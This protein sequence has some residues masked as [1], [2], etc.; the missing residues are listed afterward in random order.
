MFVSDNPIVFLYK[1]LWRFSKGFRKDIVI[2]TLLFVGANISLLIQPF[3][4]GYMLNVIQLEGV[5]PASL[6]KIFW[7]L[8]AFFLLDIGNWFF[9]G[10]AR[11]MERRSAYRAEIQYKSYMLKGV[12]HLPAQWH[13]DHHSGDTIDKI[14]KSSQALYEFAETN[15]EIIQIIVRMIGAYAALLFFYPPAGVIVFIL[16][17][18]VFVAVRWFDTRLMN[19]YAEVYR[20]ENLAAAKVY[21]TVSNITTVIILRIER[22]IHKTVVR[23]M[24]ES[25]PLYIKS[26]KMNEWKWFS[27]STLASIML[28]SILALYIF[29]Q[30]HSGAPVLVGTLTILYGYLMRINDEFFR[31]TYMYSDT[32]RRKTALKNAEPIWQEFRD[33]ELPEGEELSAQWK[34][35]AIRDLSFSYDS[36]EGTYIHLDNV[37]L[38]IKRGEKVAFVG[39]SG[40]GKTTMLK[41]IRGLYVPQKVHVAVDNVA[42]LHGFASINESIALIPQDPEIFATTI[43][44]N[45]TVGVDYPHTLVEHM[46]Q[47][48]QFSDVVKR[49]PKGYES[50]VV[51]K[52]VNLSGGEKQRLALARG[53]LASR[54]KQLLLLDEPTSSVDPY[55]ERQI[56]SNIFREFRTLTVLSSIHRLHLLPLFDRVVFFENGK[57]I[58]TGHYTK[59]IETCEPFRK[60]WDAYTATLKK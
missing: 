27:T 19:Q 54:D 52:G 21:D 30:Y 4:I 55:N 23:A 49:L 59:L 45:I 53:L 7:S 41:V 50:S 33:Q 38:T 40:A 47:L 20:L 10:P 29:T 13:T 18:A 14:Q 9:H 48:A 2:Y 35:I 39:H 46:A 31:V 25:F 12:M 34:E 56:Y 57:V 5:T 26:T 16:F 32:V 43:E 51:E 36:A 11:I 1:K 44:E 28:C 3:L 6:P 15:F 37:S 60:A 17:V 58:A 22:L 24:K 8:F 42:L